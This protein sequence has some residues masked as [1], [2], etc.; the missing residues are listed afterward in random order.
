MQQLIKNVEILLF[1][2]SEI[3]I[4]TSSESYDDS[5]HGLVS[6]FSLFIVL[7]YII[8]TYRVKKLARSSNDKKTTSGSV[9]KLI[10]LIDGLSLLVM[11]SCLVVFLTEVYFAVKVKSV[12]DLVEEQSTP[13][14]VAFELLKDISLLVGVLAVYWYFNCCHEEAKKLYVLANL[15]HLS[16]SFTTEVDFK[17]FHTLLKKKQN[18]TVHYPTTRI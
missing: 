8:G 10:E 15:V 3:Y 9:I 1:K 16:P 6:G 2:E 17:T 4:K 14:S 11:F 5:M 13:V 18:S 7:C 12:E